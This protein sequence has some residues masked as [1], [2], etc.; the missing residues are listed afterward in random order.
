MGFSPRID[1]GLDHEFR[2]KS[3][4]FEDVLWAQV[5]GSKPRVWRASNVGGFEPKVMCFCPQI[6]RIWTTSFGPNP[7]DLKVFWRSQAYDFQSKS[8]R[9]EDVLEVEASFLKH[10]VACA[11]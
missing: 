8:N 5:Y 6:D 3:Y 4:R 1:G 9:F 10:L 2:F 11:V 7:I